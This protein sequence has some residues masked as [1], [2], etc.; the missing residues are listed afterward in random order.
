MEENQTAKWY[1]LHTYSG[2]ENMVKENLL[3]VF[4]KN[5]MEDRLL[6]TVILM[7]DVVEEKNGKK[8]IVQRRLMPTYVFVKMIYDNSMWHMVTNTRGVTGFVGPQ[9]RPLPLEDD[10]VK[11][12]HLEKREVTVVDFVVGDTVKVVDGSFEGQVGTVE[13]IDL[14]SKKCKICINM[15]GHLT[16]VE[17]EL[18]MVEKLE[19]ISAE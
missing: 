12:L 9:G 2:Y 4:K 13:S 10:E 7:E 5:D 6:E 8:K 19:S 17:I 1:V 3:L 11:R 14:T 16:P 15:F 18:A